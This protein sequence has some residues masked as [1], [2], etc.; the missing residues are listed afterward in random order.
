[1]VAATPPMPWRS[2]PRMPCVT[3]WVMAAPVTRNLPVCPAV[4]PVAVFLF[5]RFLVEVSIPFPFRV[6]PGRRGPGHSRDPPMWSA[7]PIVDGPAGCPFCRERFLASAME[8][9]G[10]VR[11]GVF[12]NESVVGPPPFGD[13]KL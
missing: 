12:C 9:N 7:S 13:G 6:S 1:M 5:L 11:G 10:A 4:I 2:G 3:V 8:M